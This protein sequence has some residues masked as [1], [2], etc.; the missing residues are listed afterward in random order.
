MLRFVSLQGQLEDW[1]W[2]FV[3]RSFSRRSLYLEPD[4]RSFTIPHVSSG[5]TAVAIL[6]LKESEAQAAA[7]EL[8]TFA[9]GA[10]EARFDP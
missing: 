4:V 1:G 2:S 5:C 8:I 7:E 9:R 10:Y 3:V 6:D